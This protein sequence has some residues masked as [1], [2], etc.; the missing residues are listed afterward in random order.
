MNKFI[1][2]IKNK[3]Y[4]IIPNVLGR[5][6]TK[7]LK[8][9]V[10]KYYDIDSK[11][12]KPNFLK[13]K[14]KDK[15]VY[16]LQNK[17]YFFIKIFS[18]KIIVDIA[19]YFLN[20]PYY[21]FLP[22]EKPNYILK[23]YNA[24][25]SINKLDLHIDSYMPFKGDLTYMMQFVFMLEDSDINNGCSVV[26]NGSHKSGKFCNRNSKK[27]KNL[28]ANAGDLI[29]WDSRL[30]H[31]ARQNKNNKTRWSLVATLTRWFIKQS[32]DITKSLPNSIYRK[33]TNQQKLFLGYCSLPPYNE[34]IG[35]NTKADYSKLR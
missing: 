14:N 17:D 1:N 25:S 29:I 28:I 34:F 18:K 19:K 24:R 32:M 20:D 11:R 9:L 35:V 6:E 5:N 31:G 26:V 30:W 7:R 21:Q 10:E 23:Y 4:T 12:K 15:T 22:K 13:H 33:C 16:N 2:Q 3:G 27:I 8:K